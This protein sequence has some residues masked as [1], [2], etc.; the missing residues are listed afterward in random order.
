M[1]KKFDLAYRFVSPWEGGFVKHPNDPGGAT[2][3]GISLRWLQS[4]GIDVN[5]DG[6]I[7]EI[8][9]RTL[10]PDNARR[11]FELF[12]WQNLGLETLPLRVGVAMFDGSAN[13]GFGR[14]VRQLQEA[15]NLLNGSNLR[16]DGVLGPATREVVFA[17]SKQGGGLNLCNNML[18]VRVSYYNRLVQKNRNLKP[19]LAGWLNRTKALSDYLLQ[20]PDDED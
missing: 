14:A 6:A 12:F 7:N 1:S 16:V 13:M 2:N 19:F 9:I 3:Y 11:Y 8:D 20:L 10:K 15:C 18:E 17:L 4:M 5:A